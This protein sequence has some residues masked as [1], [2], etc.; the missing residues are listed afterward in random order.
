MKEDA[1]WGRNAN[2]ASKSFDSVVMVVSMGHEALR[3][4]I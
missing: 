3:T 1:G 2:F 4:L